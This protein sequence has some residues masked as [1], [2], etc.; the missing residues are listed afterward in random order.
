MNT[1]ELIKCFKALSDKT[2]LRLFYMLREY[3]LNVNEIV[4]VVGMIQSGVSRHLKILLESGLLTARK[5]GSFTYYSIAG[6]RI[7]RTLIE[8]I[9]QQRLDDTTFGEDVTAAAEMIHIRQNRTKRF[10]KS[11]APKWDRLKKD[12]LGDF[13]LNGA[14]KKRI[15]SGKT[16]SDLGCGTGELFECLSEN[17]Y[18]KLIGIDSSPDMLDQARIR[19]ANKP[20]IELRLGEVEHLPMKNEEIDTAAMAM[21]LHHVSQ[22]RLPIAEVFRVMKPGGSFILSDF[23]KHDNE[24]IKAIIGGSWLGFEK[25]QIKSWLTESG[26]TV[27]AVHSYSVNHN[28]TINIFTAKKH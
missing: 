15:Q 9:G 23:Q 21:V 5:E 2:R 20:R 7:A 19:L 11:V 8:M 27:K 14:L 18:K 28:L 1:S 16:I 4:L 25:K 13:D 17:H 12:V 26:F 10:F 22:P 3:E 24:S 6:N